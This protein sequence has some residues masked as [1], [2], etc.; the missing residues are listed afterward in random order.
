MDFEKM[1][2]SFALIVVGV[3]IWILCMIFAVLRKMFGEA[4]VIGIIIGSFALALPVGVAS[5]YVVGGSWSQSEFF[6]WTGF[7]WLF[8]GV[9]MTTVP[10]WKW[11]R[12]EVF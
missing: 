4:V 6:F 8:L 10:L 5:V 11:F 3:V 2:T 7:W 12:R 1:E 9:I